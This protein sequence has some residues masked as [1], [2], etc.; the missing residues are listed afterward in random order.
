M[1]KGR[2]RM[3]WTILADLVGLALSYV[4]RVIVP[5]W[6]RSWLPKP[7]STGALW[8][9]EHFITL[10]S[11]PRFLQSAFLPN[12]GLCPFSVKGEQTT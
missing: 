7:L 2:Y 11:L 6:V 4:Y 9:Y 10:L 5:A 8:L 1:S 3:M 12:A